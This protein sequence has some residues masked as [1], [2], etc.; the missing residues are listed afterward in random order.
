[1]I[2][3]FNLLFSEANTYLIGRMYGDRK[4][5]LISFLILLSPLLILWTLIAGGQYF[6]GSDY[7]SY[8]DLFN[9]GDLER[10]EPGFATILNRFRDIGIYGQFYYYFLYAVSFIFMGMIIYQ[11][12]HKSIYIFIFIFLTFTGL[13]H[14]QLNILRQ[15]VATY[16]GTYG[17]MMLIKEKRIESIILILLASSIHFC[18]LIFFSVFLLK[19]VH[20]LKMKTM[21]L[22][23]CLSIVLSILINTNSLFL[24]DFLIPDIYKKFI[25][26]GTI[27]DR[28]VLLKIT[29]YIFIP[30]FMF[31]LLKSA[32]FNLNKKQMIL[33]QIG[34]LS[35]CLKISFLN[36][37][38]ISRIFDFLI[39]LM[40]FPLYYYFL[41]LKANKGIYYISCIFIFL[42]IYLSKVLIFPSKEYLYQSI[43]PSLF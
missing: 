26:A 39:I 5:S 18:A 36:L 42:A 21:F 22:I 4:V 8:M 32:D 38:I 19:K 33:F 37:T 6:V 27:E 35:F 23:L 12:N 3:V 10:Y 29:K 17:V 7:I 2:Y 14:N 16:I 25:I 31:S 15:A 28:S 43:Y 34:F 9:G 41:Y 1:M 13:F 11:I 24:F 20:R 30:F 40:V